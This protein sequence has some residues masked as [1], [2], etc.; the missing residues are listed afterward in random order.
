MLPA[1]SRFSYSPKE[2]VMNHSFR[3]ILARVALGAMAFAL[4]SAAAAAGPKAYVGNFKDNTV[5]AIDTGTGAVVATIPVVAGPHGM[6][7]SPDG[8]TLY[9][10]GDGSSEVS[11]I[12]TATDRVT[13]KINVGK[14]PHGMAMAG[15]GR[16]LMV[17]V[18]GEDKVVFI[19]TASQQVVA[20]VPVPKP[21]TVS[22]RPDGKV[23]Y[24]SSQEPGKFALVVVDLATRAVARTLPLEKTPRDLEFGYDGKALYFTMAGVNA[25]QVLDPS[26]D[27]VVAEIPTGASPHIAGF[28]RGAPA[29]TVVVQGP[30]ELTLF[31]PTTNAV[32]RSVAVGKQPHW[33]AA[34]G[35]GMSA[36]VTNEG[37]NDVTVVDL[38]TGQTKTIAVGNAP[39]K[40]VVQRAAVNA[41][42]SGARISI[43]NFAFVPPEIAVVAGQS[44]TWSNDDGAPHGLMFKDGAAGTDLL[45]PGKSFSRTFDKPGTYEYA[46]STHPY[47][48]GKVVVR[49]S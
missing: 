1:S 46:C 29:G 2:I 9:V 39:R 41:A 20:S 33:V 30:G 6:G 10:S 5:S 26:S 4:A 42:A 32:L 35:D 3:A 27:K 8:R 36:Y 16:T 48:T 24:V 31:N 43:A 38:A 49:T 23:A 37:S 44:V 22:I 47:M 17:C 25:V 45:L 40:V 15:D 14:T 11:V 21:H 7:V 18:Y 13:G 12:D 19:D 34:S 28:F